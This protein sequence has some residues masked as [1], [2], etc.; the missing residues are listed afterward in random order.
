MSGQ[1]ATAADDG[2]GL[3]RPSPQDQEVVLDAWSQVLGQVLPDRDCDWKEQLQA[4]K[5]ES[6]TA[7]TKDRDRP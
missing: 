4:I 7:P 2:D 1:Y 3:P 6:L 5:A